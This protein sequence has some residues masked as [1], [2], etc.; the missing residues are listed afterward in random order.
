MR[1]PW[2]KPFFL[3]GG[4][5]GGGGLRG[6]GVLSFSR[7]PLKLFLVDIFLAIVFTNAL[8]PSTTK[9]TFLIIC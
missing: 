6:A 5:G 3:G 9:I 1:C 8:S 7:E 2:H 4:G